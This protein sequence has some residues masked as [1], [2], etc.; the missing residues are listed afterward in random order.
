MDLLTLTQKLLNEQ[1]VSP[2][3]GNCQQIIA[4]LL[5]S[6][7]FSI[8]PQNINDT[9]NLLA[10]KGN[11]KQP[12]VLLLGH[13]D[14]VPAGIGWDSKPFEATIKQQ[15]IYARG[16]V[17]MKAAVAAM[18]IAACKVDI[19]FGRIA[20]MLTSDEEA[21]GTYGIK[22][23]ITNWLPKLQPLSS[24]LVGEPTSNKVLGDTIKLGRRGSINIKLAISGIQ[25]HAAYPELAVNPIN[26]AAKAI[27]ELQAIEFSDYEDFPATSICFTGI[28]SS[29]DVCNLIPG[30]VELGFNIRFAP[31]ICSDDLK[32]LICDC[33]E[34]T[35]IEYLITS[36]QE[37]ALPFKSQP[38]GLTRS[39][40]QAIMKHTNNVTNISYD[41]GTSDG[42]FIAKHCQEVIEFGALRGLAHKANE[43]ISI[44]DLHTLE[45][46]YLTTLEL[47]LA[48]LLQCCKKDLAI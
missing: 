13:T 24:C 42:R 33:L 16:A 6:N 15:R 48:D 7:G 45:Q 30:A 43:H 44:S 46:I 36:W 18:V 32:S 34:T 22:S 2:N 10:I 3:D 11:A 12:C 5:T 47:A 19:N 41:G 39:I 21:S 9:S 27:S 40:K 23:A 20:I 25:G 8:Y 29:S 37:S 35:N 17:D 38:A 31:N 14:V 4:E 26:I 1:S 28:A